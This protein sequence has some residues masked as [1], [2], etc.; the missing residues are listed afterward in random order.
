M[1]ASPGLIIA[2][3]ASGSG[4][5]V[6]TLALLRALGNAGVGVASAKAGPDYIDPAF[7][8][9]ASGRACI[10]LDPWAMRPAT[11]ANLVG[12]QSHSADL[13][14]AE[15]VMGLFDGINLPGRPDMGSTADLAALTGW[16]VVLV[17]DAGRQAASVG[18]LVSGFAKHRDDV[19]IAG[20]IFNRVASETHRDV[21]SAAV[22][23]ATPDIAILGAVP[24]DPALALPERHLGLVPAGEHK[25][26]EPFLETA[27]RIVT[28]SI[29]L[30]A[31]QKLARP[32]RLV[33][34]ASGP[35]SPLPP[36]GQTIAVAQDRAFGFAYPNVLQAWRD[37]G[38][39]IMP[40]SPLGD[41]AP[42]ADADA[43]YLPGGYPELH[44]GQLAAAATFLEGLRA[45]ASRGAA[46]FGECG[47]YM[48][49]GES[50][51][52][53]EGT[54]HAMAGLLPVE[55]SFAARRLHLGYRVA[56]LTGAGPLGAPGNAFRGHEF[57]YATVV[58]EGPGDAL[59][60]ARNAAGADLG[61]C[62][63]TKGTVSGSFIHLIDRAA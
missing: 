27:A 7:H 4:K 55:T 35:S 54:T 52:D 8:R 6:V 51:T 29:D 59:F 19:D 16:P 21:L 17:V 50:L 49:L 62:G 13:V 30:T 9:F 40:F 28:E 11:L 23:R 39:Q 26:L 24:R 56:T 18:A 5:T 45:A 47:G 41:Q 3:P 2:A 57:H 10:N 33:A 61:R 43:V 48:V 32:S 36:L 42:A 46:L 63:R 31:F 53:A 25:A 20:V 44:A 37:A 38:A 60:E 1:P 22:A 12:A 15:G 14:L 58:R 34:P